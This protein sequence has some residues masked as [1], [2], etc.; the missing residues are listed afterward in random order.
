MF[1]FQSNLWLA[2][3]VSRSYSVES[4]INIL[5][6]EFC[7]TGF[8]LT[9]S[10]VLLHILQWALLL[11]LNDC[12]YMKIMYVNCG[13]INEYGSQVIFVVM[14]AANLVV[15]ISHEL[16]KFRPVRE[17]NQWSLRYRCSSLPTELTSQLGSWSFC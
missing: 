15:R 2:I 6:R 10:F 8:W 14:H 9:A 5:V 1:S 11:C 17:L 4:T 3:Y 13:L 16:E 12:E 7:Y